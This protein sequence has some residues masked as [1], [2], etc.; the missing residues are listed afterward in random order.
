MR[1]GMNSLSDCRTYKRYRYSILSTYSRDMEY[2]TLHQIQRAFFGVLIAFIKS[3]FDASS[4]FS[5]SLIL[6][7]FA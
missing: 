6:I 7:Y 5:N 3:F 2:H 1:Q 4:V